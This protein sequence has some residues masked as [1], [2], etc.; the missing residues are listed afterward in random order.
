M[1][2][3]WEIIASTAVSSEEKIS[4]PITRIP[5]KYEKLIAFCGSGKSESE[6]ER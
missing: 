4:F 6:R 3:L 1:N 5:I 2:N